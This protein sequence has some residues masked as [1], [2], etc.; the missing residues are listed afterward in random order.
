MI[1]RAVTLFYPVEGGRINRDEL[2]SELTRLRELIGIVRQ[3]Y[4]IEVRTWRVTLPFIEPTW[5][6]E[7][8]AALVGEVSNGLGYIHSSLNIPLDFRV[9]VDR[10]VSAFIKSNSYMSIWVGDFNYLSDYSSSLFVN[11]LRKVVELGRWSASRRIAALIGNPILTPYYPDS[12][13]LGN[14]HGIAMSL[15]YTDDIPTSRDGLGRAMREV[16]RR[17]EDVGKWIAE[18]LGIDYLG[19]DVSLS[20]W[21]WHSVVQVIERV[22]GIQFGGPGTLSAVHDLNR[23]IWESSG[24]VKTTGF[25]EVMLPLAEDELLKE[26]VREGLV[27]FSKLVSYAAM[28]VAGVDM[29]PIR[30]DQLGLVHY[31]IRDLHAIVSVK[32]RSVGL[33]LIPYPGSEVEADLEDFGSTPVM[34]MLR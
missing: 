1:I 9:D 14:K 33:R 25:N 15:L 11:A 10:L 3:N 28:C 24:S 31:L 7:E 27:T 20:P 26:R 13:N 22:Y 16:F 34:D 5:N 29:V 21:G 23:A 32:R 4:G 8:V 12:I 19:I 6:Y 2:R 30:A 18:N 17:A